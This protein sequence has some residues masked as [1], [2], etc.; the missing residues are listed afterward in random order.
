MKRSRIEN[1]IWIIFAGVG[2]IFTIIGIIIVSN[3]FNYENKIDTKGVITE[4]SSYRNSNGNRNH[5]VYISYNIDGKEYESRLNSYSSDFYEGKEIDIYYDKDNPNKIGV[6][7]LDLIFLIFPVI[8]LIFLVIGGTGI[9]VKLNKKKLEKKLK[10]NGE[11]I[12]ANYIETVLNTAYTVNGRHPYN[13]ICEW[14]NPE[15]DK[16]Y[17]LK[18][19]NIWVNPENILEEKN[20]KTLPVYISLKNK[21]QYFIDID[22][23]T[24]DGV[25]L[26]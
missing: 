25:D 16:K 8:G 17:I 5:D 10:E 15:D 22:S 1:L 26:R 24:E 13:I 18:S 19:K 20:I 23:L 11:L 7:S 9:L 3:I 12:Y 4:I 6:K 21:K 2:L 14:N